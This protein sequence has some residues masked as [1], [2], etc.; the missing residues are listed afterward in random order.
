MS[1]RITRALALV[2]FV[3]GGAAC[4]K[5]AEVACNDTVT[6]LVDAFERCGFFDPADRVTAEE[7]IEEGAT[8]GRGCRNIV[9]IRD[10]DELRRACLP[11]LDTYPCATLQEEIPASCR[12]QLVFYRD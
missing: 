6:A 1:T 9:R 5:P 4:A 7:E 3:M 12:G 10:E 2:A 11:E 8:L